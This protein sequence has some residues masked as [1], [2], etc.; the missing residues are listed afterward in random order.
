M[1][2]WRKNESLAGQVKAK[3]LQVDLLTQMF[4]TKEQD[5]AEQARQLQQQLQEAKREV[6]A[7][8][9]LPALPTLELRPPTEDSFH[10]EV[11]IQT[12]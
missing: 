6:V 9:N 7:K 11:P 10:F 2:H 12:L 4:L 1:M 3:E 5:L 8:D